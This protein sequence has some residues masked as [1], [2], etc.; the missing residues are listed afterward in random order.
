MTTWALQ[1]AKARLSELVEK[2]ASEG[3]QTITKRG[4]RAAVVLSA[5]EFDS[6]TKRARPTLK[7]FLEGDVGK[8]DYDIP[9]PVRGSGRHRP[10]P[11]FD[12]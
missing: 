3:P 2:T 1:D 10:I 9:I 11:E 4:A 8:F 6:L 12:D 5:E 7:E